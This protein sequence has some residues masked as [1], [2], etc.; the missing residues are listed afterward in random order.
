MARRIRRKL[1]REGGR[2]RGGGAGLARRELCRG[3]VRGPSGRPRRGARTAGGIPGGRRHAGGRGPERGG[4]HLREALRG[5]EE[6]RRGGLVLQEGYSGRLEERLHGEEQEGVQ[7]CRGGPAGE[8]GLRD[9]RQ[10][11]AEVALHDPHPYCWLE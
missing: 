6:G 7:G 3:E 1:A 5:Q 2:N 11:V 9:G 8:D 4:G 10:L